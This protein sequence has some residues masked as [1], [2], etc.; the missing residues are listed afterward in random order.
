MQIMMGDQSIDTNDI[1]DLWRQDDAK[2]GIS[3]SICGVLK[4]IYVE[5]TRSMDLICADLNRYGQF[6]LFKNHL[7]QGNNIA[8]SSLKTTTDKDTEI[9]EISLIIYP[10]ITTNE[11]ARIENMTPDDHLEF[12]R[13]LNISKGYAE[14][15]I[16]SHPLKTAPQ[17]RQYRNV[18]KI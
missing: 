3:R 6:F 9:D 15:E 5:D 18:P 12:Q 2:I 11:I 16:F 17:L 8:G 13:L 7:F 14:P 10:Y 1:I 4:N